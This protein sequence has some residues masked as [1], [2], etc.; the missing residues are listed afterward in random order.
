MAPRLLEILPPLRLTRLCDD[1]FP[2]ER[3][4]GVR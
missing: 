2:A 3:G 1:G 4:K